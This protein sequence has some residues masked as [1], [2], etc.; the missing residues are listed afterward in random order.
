[1]QCPRGGPFNVAQLLERRDG[2]FG[3]GL[4]S[5]RRVPRD[6]ASEG[7]QATAGVQQDLRVVMEHGWWAFSRMAC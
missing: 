3:A 1:M 2:P 6:F 4:S 5:W 7:S